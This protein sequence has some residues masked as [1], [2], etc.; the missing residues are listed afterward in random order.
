MLV[1][2]CEFLSRFAVLLLFLKCTLIEIHTN[3]YVDV[4][5]YLGTQKH[6]ASTHK[7]NWMSS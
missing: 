1:N 6:M 7:K 4:L 3:I 5:G 2:I